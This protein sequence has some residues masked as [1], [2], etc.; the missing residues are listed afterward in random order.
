MSLTNSIHISWRNR[1]ADYTLAAD[2]SV[3]SAYPLTNCQNQIANQW[4]V[5]DMAGETTVA[6]TGSG[7]DFIPVNCFAM[8]N[9]SAPPGT[10]LRLRLYEGTGQTGA[11]LYDSDNDNDGDHQVGN[12]VPFGSLIAGVDG[13]GSAFED[14][15]RL[16]PHYS[17]WFDVV[18]CRSWRIDITNASGFTD[19]VL[20]VDK[21][22]L[23]YAYGLRYGVNNGWEFSQ[24]NEAEDRRKPG[25]GLD[26][27]EDCE[28]RALSMQ[29][30]PYSLEND[31]LHTLLHLLNRA[32]RGGDLLVT[33]DPNDI[34]SKRYLTTSIYKR[35]GSK[36]AFTAAYFNANGLGLT[37]EEN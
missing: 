6:I 25:G 36:L 29:W 20:R 23:G 28:R 18:Q 31:E 2:V 10:T 21:F 3:E 34:R 14:E 32:G 26:T 24:V 15:G 17:L 12:K 11:V 30:S 1:L 19:D 4:T 35:T 27:L 13:L 8:H 33:L 37:L 22:W 16:K 9:H 7:A 5:F